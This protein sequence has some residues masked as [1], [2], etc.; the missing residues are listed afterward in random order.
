MVTVWYISILL[1][2]A[3]IQVHYIIYQIRSVLISWIKSML[4]NIEGA[5]KKGTIQ[6]HWR[7]WIHKTQN[8]A[9]QINARENRR[10]QSRMDNPEKMAILDTQYT[11]QS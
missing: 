4:E 9:K 10:G 6:R 1:S 2:V 7:H 8:K 11:G 3:I 5:I